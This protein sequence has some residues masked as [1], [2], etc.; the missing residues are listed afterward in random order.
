MAE[1]GGAGPAGVP[2]ELVATIDSLVDDSVLVQMRPRHSTAV[3][4]SKQRESMILSLSAS[5]MGLPPWKCRHAHSARQLCPWPP[6]LAYFPVTSSSSTIEG[7]SRGA[8][9]RARSPTRGRC[10]ASPASPN[11]PKPEKGHRPAQ[12]LLPVHEQLCVGAGDY[13][14]A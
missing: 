3:I 10:S 4:S 2:P 12:L 14:G 9:S 6:S 8:C 7:C 13:R 5:P 11:L 1:V